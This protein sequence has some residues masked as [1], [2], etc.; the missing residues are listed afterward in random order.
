MEER[1]A[2]KKKKAVE[3]EGKK[4]EGRKA[5]ISESSEGRDKKQT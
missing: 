5:R 3:E 4:K 1:K 2:E